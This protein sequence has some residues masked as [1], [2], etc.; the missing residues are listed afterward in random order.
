MLLETYRALSE[1]LDTLL[2]LLTYSVLTQVL[3]FTSASFLVWRLWTFTIRPA[4]H[5]SAP[6]PLPYWIPCK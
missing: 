1:H 5:P 4:L 6:K 3:A 2:Y